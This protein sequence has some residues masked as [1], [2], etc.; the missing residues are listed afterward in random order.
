MDKRAKQ[1]L[2]SQHQCHIDTTLASL[3]PQSMAKYRAYLQQF[4]TILARDR[5]VAMIAF[6]QVTN[7]LAQADLEKV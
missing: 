7:R 1:A 3:N 4:E 5:E 6:A 2:L